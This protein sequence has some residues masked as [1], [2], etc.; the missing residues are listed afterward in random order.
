ML[1]LPTAAAV[2]TTIEGAIRRGTAA[3]AKPL[4]RDD[5]RIRN[6]MIDE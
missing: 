6:M 2:G 4:D 1:L 3:A 5:V